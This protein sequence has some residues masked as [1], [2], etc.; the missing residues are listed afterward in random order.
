MV[1]RNENRLKRITA[2]IVT[3]AMSISMVMTP[4]LNAMAVSV[5]PIQS[6]VEDKDYQSQ[7]EES[8]AELSKISDVES[9]SDSEQT[10]T[11]I[12]ETE[13]SQSNSDLKTTLPDTIRNKISGNDTKGEM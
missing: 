1:R 11:N 12:L 5:E 7:D 9:E 3:I 4:S 2:L 10:E 13:Q 8:E 6:I